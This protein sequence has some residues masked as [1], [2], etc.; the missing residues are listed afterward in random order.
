MLGP[1][2]FE[3]RLERRKRLTHCHGTLFQWPASLSSSPCSSPP[4]G[5]K[6]RSID[7]RY[8]GPVNLKSYDCQDITRS[9]LIERVCYDEA[10]R[11]MVVRR[12]A[13]H[14]QYCELPKD[15]VVAFLNA[16]SMGQYFNA[17]IAGNGKSRPIRLR[18]AQGVMNGNAVSP[19]FPRT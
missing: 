10:N 15:V 5:R 19:T 1:V 7:V 6:P 3:H 16:P 4:P 9:S 8:L 17:N 14:D 18:D 11:H 2:E 13:V 12:N